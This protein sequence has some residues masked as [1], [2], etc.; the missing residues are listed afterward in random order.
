MT[1]EEKNHILKLINENYPEIAVMLV[2]NYLKE[3]ESDP[4]KIEKI[5]KILT[6][7]E[8]GSIKPDYSA[9]YI[10]NDGPGDIKQIT[11]SYGFIEFGSLKDLVKNYAN[12]SGKYSKEFEKWV[13]RVGQKPS[14][15]S[16]SEFKNLLKK[17]GDDPVM[18][19][20]Q[21]KLFEERY[22]ARAVEW[23]KEHGF[24]KPLSFLS[25]ANEFL[26][27]G[28]ILSFLRKRHSAYP[29]SKGGKEEMW[30]KRQNEVR[31]EWLKTHRRPILRN[32]VNR[33]QLILDLISKGNWNLDGVI[34][35]E[36]LKVE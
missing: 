27:S 12:A 33:T 31:H 19:E 14:L 8:Q 9:I 20:E 24:T 18:Q 22:I 35:V 10:Y 21:D 34:T 13:D 17:A 28:S 4:L 30:I 3:Q 16:N 15:H 6:V 25:I 29:P 7:W 1:Q 23:G 2:A 36:G 11:V 26:H 32:T 5:R